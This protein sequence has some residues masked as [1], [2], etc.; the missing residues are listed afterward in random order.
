[1]VFTSKQ[2]EQT[3]YNPRLN[4]L[5]QQE[6]TTRVVTVLHMQTTYDMISRLLARFNIKAIHIPTKEEHPLLKPVKDDLGLRAPGCTVFCV[7]A[8]RC[9]LYTQAVTLR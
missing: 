8:V 3:Q 7:N 6:K 4:S 1:V 9:T 2:E 5:S